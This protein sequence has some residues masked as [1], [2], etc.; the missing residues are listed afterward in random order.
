M[1]L[2]SN[3]IDHED[4]PLPIELFHYTDQNGLLG[5]INSNSFWATKI[6]C[7]ND[8]SEYF[9][10]FKIAENILESLR[11]NREFD[12]TKI[13]YLIDEMSSFQDNIYVGSFSEKGDSLSQWRAYCSGTSGYAIGFKCEKL[14][15]IARNQGFYLSKCIY[16]SNIQ[17]NIIHDLI[18]RQLTEGFFP[19]PSTYGYNPETRVLNIPPAS[20]FWHELAQIAPLIKDKGFQEEQEWRLISIDG[21]GYNDVNFRTGVSFIV[22]YFPLELLNLEDIISSIIIG[23]TPHPKISQDTLGML[24]F[25]KNFSKIRLPISDVP[26]RFW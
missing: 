4:V 9:L 2:I 20:R 16:D 5:I 6:T 13:H 10:A 18:L 7:L 26:Y 12:S 11:Q 19:E 17:E 1:S 24:L 15:E 25:K 3:L 14:D 21:I 22:P 23:P 8:S